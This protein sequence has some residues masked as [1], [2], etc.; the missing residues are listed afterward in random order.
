MY[1]QDELKQFE[2]KILNMD[3][4]DFLKKLP[5]KSIDLVLTD[6]PYGIN[7]G[8]QLKNKG[9]G[10]NT[11][12]NGWRDFNC[13]DWDK[14]KIDK[15]IFDELFRVSKNQIIWGGNYYVNYL[16]P[17][18]CW[19]VWNKCQK[20]FSLADGELVWTSF[21]KAL[22]IYDYSRGNHLQ[23][24]NRFHA[25]QKPLNLF[26]WCLNKFSKENDLILDCFSGSG[27]TAIACQDM[28]RRFI[29]I[30]KDKIYFEKS[31]KRLEDFKKQLIFEF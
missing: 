6:P 2:N 15:I 31:I 9:K 18:Q 7:Y 13:G 11:D 28:K 8:K 20:E 5:D 27:V 22:R 29:C 17:S 21:N 12:K 14:N 26:K 25:T 16:T 19:L 30:E 23:E 10:F 1:S 4:Y 3:C 24:K